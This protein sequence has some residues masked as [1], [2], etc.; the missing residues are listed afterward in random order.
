MLREKHSRQGQMELVDIEA[1]VPANH[2]L[3]KIDKYID[4]SF[5]ND[6]CRP[7]YCEDIGRPAIEP[8]IMFKMLFLGY[9]YGI[10][11]ET[12]LAEEVR[13]NIAYRWFLGYGI[14]DKTPD[15]SVIWQNRIR[16]FNGTDIPRRIFDEILRQAMA[17]GLVGGRILYSD[18]THLKASANKNK[19]KEAEVRK[20]T[21][22]YLDDLNKA[23]NEDRAAH[24]K[25]PLKFDKKPACPD[26]E[27]D[28]DYFDDDNGSGNGETKTDLRAVLRVVEKRPKP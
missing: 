17:H 26:D 28:E 14:A 7:Y 13:M 1:L 27:D 9:L 3:R 25:K 8:V 5:I 16:R 23:I 6:M 24:G 2:L 15:A 4:F 11:S 20:E 10:R 18:S 19:F 12:R 22:D 21:Q